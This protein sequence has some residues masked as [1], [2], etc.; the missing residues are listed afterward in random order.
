MAIDTR[1]RHVVVGCTLFSTVAV[2]GCGTSL[3]TSPTPTITITTTDA[4][5]AQWIG[6]YCTQMSANGNYAQ[7][8]A[9][10]AR[11]TATP[12]FTQTMYSLVSATLALLGGNIAEVTGD[13]PT[14][15]AA[16]S[17]RT[18]LLNAYQNLS[19]ALNK[20]KS[21]LSTIPTADPQQFAADYRSITNNVSVVAQQTQDAIDSYPAFV[22][23]LRN[24]PGCK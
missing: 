7:P 4:M 12:A 21:Q 20:A 13:R 2:A 16:T 11:M 10:A 23:P 9:D 24:Y 8:F 5:I 17:A 6:V 14:T 18:F 1:A 15:P 19:N 22:A 3:P